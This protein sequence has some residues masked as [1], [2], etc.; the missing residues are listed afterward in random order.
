MALSTYWLVRTLASPSLLH[1]SFLI[2]CSNA[3][4]HSCLSGSRAEDFRD[5]SVGGD[6]FSPTPRQSGSSTSGCRVSPSNHFVPPRPIPKLRGNSRLRGGA[7]PLF[8]T[9]W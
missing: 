2:F 1:A 9:S 6:W 7:W 5:H 3:V 8:P 4:Q